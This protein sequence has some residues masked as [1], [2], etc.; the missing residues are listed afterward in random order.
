MLAFV[1]SKRCT[2][3]IGG[4]KIDEMTLKLTRRQETA[5]E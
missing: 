4:M 3:K 5:L 1:S 2:I